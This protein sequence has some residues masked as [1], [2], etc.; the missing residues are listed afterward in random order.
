MLHLHRILGRSCR[1]SVARRVGVA[2]LVC[3][4][5][6]M[7]AACASSGSA[8]SGNTPSA[9]A[10]PGGGAK[11][12]TS[13]CNIIAPADFFAAIGVSGG[14]EKASTQTVNGNQIVN[15]TYK[16]SV[17][18]SSSSAIN[19]VFTSDGAAYFAKEKQNEQ[20]ILGSENS[21][22]GLGDDAFWGT[23]APLAPDALQLNVRKGN[24]IVVIEMDGSAQDGSVY[25]N[26]AKQFAQTIL[27][28]L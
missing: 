23:G 4:A 22:S 10:T 19:F 20:G 2:S 21:L 8:S 6:A 27:T 28:H 15:C 9:S 5:L 25:L 16:P 26:S 24:V 18:V 7:L 12:E 3:A 11:A 17:S 14:T 13:L 1:V